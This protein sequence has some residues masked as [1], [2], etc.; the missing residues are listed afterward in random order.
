MLF[1]THSESPVAHIDLSVKNL[2]YTGFCGFTLWNCN[3]P[4]VSFCTW[5]E[6][7]KEDKTK[8]P[9][10]SNRSDTGEQAEKTDREQAKLQVKG[11]KHSH[12]SQ[13]R[14]KS[15]R[16]L[17]HQSNKDHLAQKLGKVWLK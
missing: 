13:A 11:T 10:S 3:G 5:N 4:Q 15:T 16:A 12:K 2:A 8:A 17:S 14:N 6:V 1:Y 7:Q 9:K